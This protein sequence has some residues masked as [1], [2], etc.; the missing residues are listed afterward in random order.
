LPHFQIV[1]KANCFLDANAEARGVHFP[2]WS[3]YLIISSENSAKRA[4]AQ[5]ICHQPCCGYLCLYIQHKRHAF[6]FIVL[7]LDKA[8]VLTPM[9]RVGGDA[10]DIFFK[11]SYHAQNPEDS[12]ADDS[13]DFYVFCVLYKSEYHMEE[14][15][16]GQILSI[17]SSQT[18]DLRASLCDEEM[19]VDITTQGNQQQG[20]FMCML[21]HL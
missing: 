16:I 7:C 19:D 13:N 6:L 1:Y 18:T 11:F 17:I 20:M 9:Q 12:P 5:R 4:Q 14:G 21:P 2:S 3:I 10:N 15:G 8:E